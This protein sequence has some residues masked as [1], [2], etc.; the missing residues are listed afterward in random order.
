MNNEE[1][2]QIGDLV[3]Y[4]H[5]DESNIGIVIGFEDSFSIRNVDIYWF[6][7]ELEK[8]FLI[9]SVEDSWFL[10]SNSYQIISYIVL[11]IIKKMPMLE[12]HPIDHCGIDIDKAPTK[13]KLSLKYL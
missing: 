2:L 8:P 3:S 12:M 7:L 13:K 6:G 11:T 5:C 1:H 10:N 9:R 4:E